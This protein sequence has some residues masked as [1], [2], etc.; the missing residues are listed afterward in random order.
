MDRLELSVL[1]Q[2]ALPPTFDLCTCLTDADRRMDR[3]AIR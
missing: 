3:D 1:R 2:V